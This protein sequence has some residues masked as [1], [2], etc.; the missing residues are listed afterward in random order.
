MCD[1]FARVGDFDLSRN[2]TARGWLRLESPE[3]FQPIAEDASGGVYLIGSGGRILYVTS[4]ELAGV[5]AVS[6]ADAL[7]LFVA[8]PY[9]RDLLKF[10]GGGDLTE[11]KRAALVPRE[12]ACR[13]RNV[14]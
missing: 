7:S 2:A 6:L 10:S 4:D 5:I 11:M 8:F 13:K 14:S 12:G 9:W 3:S 1:A